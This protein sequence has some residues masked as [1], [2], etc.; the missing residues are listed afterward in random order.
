MCN[1]GNLRRMRVQ[2]NTIK[3][4]VEL[5]S[6]IHRSPATKYPVKA[7]YEI[8]GM[9]MNRVDHLCKQ[10]DKGIAIEK[11]LDDIDAIIKDLPGAKIYVLPYV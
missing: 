2:T 10:L 9:I 4:Y 1:I 5:A 6:I 11:E 8:L 3:N 7:I